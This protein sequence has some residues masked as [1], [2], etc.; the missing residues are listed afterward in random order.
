V[1]DGMPRAAIAAAD[2]ARV[3]ALEQIAATLAAWCA[4]QPARDGDPTPSD[5]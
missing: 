3:L 5:R 2:G 1:V 4:R